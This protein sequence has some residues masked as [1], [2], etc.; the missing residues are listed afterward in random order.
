MR[1]SGTAIDRQ[2]PGHG[3]GHAS[4]WEAAGSRSASEVLAILEPSGDEPHAIQTMGFWKTGGVDAPEL[5]AAA[6]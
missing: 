4:G 3:R 2:R 5:Q 1:R 6:S